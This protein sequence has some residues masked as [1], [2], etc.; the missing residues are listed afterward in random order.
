MSVSG[1]ADAV[2]ADKLLAG[3]H[4]LT[5]VENLRKE[6][7]YT[8]DGEVISYDD[9]Y[10]KMQTEID[11]LP[12]IKLLQSIA[13][14][15]ESQYQI[16]LVTALER[17]SDSIE[18]I[19]SRLI[20]FNSKLKVAEGRCKELKASFTAW[21]V[22]ALAD[23]LT[24]YDMSLT[25]KTQEALA[26]S[27]FERLIG[28]VDVEVSA[29]LAAVKVQFEILAK[30]KKT[31]T[32]KFNMGK[33]QAN[34]A[35]TRTLLPDMP[36]TSSDPGSRDLLIT[37]EEAELNEMDVPAFVSKEPKL[38]EAEIAGG[39]EIKGTFRKTGDARPAEII[40]EIQNE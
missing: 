15:T 20:H 28:G 22:L 10:L 16:Q 26:G 17:L 2:Q 35:W 14:G 19:Q 13:P 11:R 8:S 1:H 23:Y 27:E 9:F 4:L 34:A 31:A 33:D 36:G 32:E 37:G 38:L 39:G 7:Q 5:Q 18:Y 6:L 24:S 3:S 12:H 25:T 30:R 21:Y 29:L 40:G